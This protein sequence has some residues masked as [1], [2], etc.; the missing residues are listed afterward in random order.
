[1]PAQFV[2]D[3]S[4]PANDL[5]WYANIPVP[6]SY[7]I[8][9]TEAEFLRW[10]RSRGAARASCT[11]RIITSRRAKS[12]GRGAIT[13]LAMPGIACLTDS[14]G[15]YIELMAG[16]YTDN[17]PDFS[18][19]APW[20]TKTFSQYWYPIREIGPACAANLDAALSVRMVD[21]VAHSRCVRYSC[22]FADA[23]VTLELRRRAGWR[24]DDDLSVSTAFL[25][26]TRRCGVTSNSEARL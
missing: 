16:V 13:N 1:M 3:G 18:F 6:T 7:M 4:Y 25:A 19:L 17:Q 5:S 20:E 9:G 11:W 8:V 23:Q 22:R 2:P 15:P 12:S 14:D 24:V 10:V 26:T 21:G